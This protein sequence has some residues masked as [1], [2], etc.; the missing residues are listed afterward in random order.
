MRV[1]PARTTS[2]IR[3]GRSAA[4]H[5]SVRY[6][7]AT[8]EIRATLCGSPRAPNIYN[9]IGACIIHFTATHGVTVSERMGGPIGPTPTI[10]PLGGGRLRESGTRPHR[11]SDSADRRRCSLRR[12]NGSRGETRRAHVR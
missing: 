11:P 1:F 8:P 7:C 12:G 2:A 5:G 3:L 10:R 4:N 6:F 9:S